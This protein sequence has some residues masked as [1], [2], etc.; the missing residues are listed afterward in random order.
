MWT[1]LLGGA[2]FL[3]GLGKLPKYP[4]HE[5]DLWSI[6]ARRHLVLTIRSRVRDSDEV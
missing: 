2:G 4:N 3:I 5:K 1:V 6:L